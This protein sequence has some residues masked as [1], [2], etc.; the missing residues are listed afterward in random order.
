MKHVSPFLLKSSCSVSAG[1]R[2][3]FREEFKL[4]L[5]QF[6]RFPI[7]HVCVG[8]YSFSEGDVIEEAME[9]QVEEPITRL[10]RRG[11]RGGTSHKHR[12]E[13]WAPE[14][15]ACRSEGAGEEG[16]WDNKGLFLKQLQASACIN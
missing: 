10:P 3:N 2:I 8:G 11:H 5:P 7:T 15:S 1:L 16:P 13:A 4:K 12:Q 6:P 9:G 14:G